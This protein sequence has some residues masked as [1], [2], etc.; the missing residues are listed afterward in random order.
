M[1]IGDL[2]PAHP[3]VIGHRG[4]GRGASAEGFL[5]NTPAGFAH[6]AR[7]GAAWVELDAKLN[8]E[9][10]LV[11]H[12]NVFYGPEPISA[13]STEQCRQAGL[14]TLDEAHAALPPGVGI[15]LEVKFGP[16]DATSSATIDACVAWAANHRSTRPVLVISFDPSVAAAAAAYRLP[17]GW[18]T[19]AGWP[20]YESV[21]SA[22]RLGCAVAL[23]HASEVTRV[24]PDHPGPAAILDLLRA[25]GVRL[26]VWDALEADVPL[27]I[28]RGVTGLCTDDIAGVLAQVA[29]LETGAA[30]N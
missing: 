20:L 17:S 11:L 21:T 2:L 6:A 10:E 22:A 5:E 30:D 16:S 8:A 26:W 13:M 29:S 27:L 18:V 9:H 25:T 3:F 23:V 12:H 28:S 4:C 14:A 1:T 19:R 7:L 24:N 15:A